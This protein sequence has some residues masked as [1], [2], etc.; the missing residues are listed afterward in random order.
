M[1]TLPS[2]HS[3]DAILPKIFKIT[4]K[5]FKNFQK[6]AKSMSLLIKKHQLQDTNLTTYPKYLKKIS[7]FWR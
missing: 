3:S 6:C 7:L 1:T 2:S 5:I 4:S